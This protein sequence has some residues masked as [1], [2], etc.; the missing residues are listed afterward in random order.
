MKYAASKPIHVIYLKLHL[1]PLNCVNVIIHV[2]V[3]QFIQTLKVLLDL[4]LFSQ[5]MFSHVWRCFF[6]PFV[7]NLFIVHELLVQYVGHIKCF[8]LIHIP[9]SPQNISKALNFPSNSEAKIILF[10][11]KKILSHTC[12]LVMSHIGVNCKFMKILFLCDE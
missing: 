7:I 11:K 10:K 4:W 3:L 12:V 6:I 1:S 8:I 9:C 2:Q 5:N